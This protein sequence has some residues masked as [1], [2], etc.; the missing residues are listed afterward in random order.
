MYGRPGKANQY[1]EKKKL[2]SEWGPSSKDYW[3]DDTCEDKHYFFWYEDKHYGHLPVSNEM[4]MVWKKSEQVK[5]NWLH[6]FT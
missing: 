3:L 2:E 6:V 1:L 5:G 4:K